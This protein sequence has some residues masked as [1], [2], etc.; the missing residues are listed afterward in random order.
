MT[1]A[2]V[3]SVG[4]GVGGTE[5]SISSLAHALSFSIEDSNPDLVVY[6]VS[7][8]SRETVLPRIKAEIPEI[9]SMEVV[10]D[11][12]DDLQAIFNQLNPT[13]KRL[14]KEHSSLY[15]DFT[16]G[17]KAMTS[18]LVMLA[19]LYEANTLSNVVGI[20]ANGLVQRGTE[21]IHK[22]SPIFATAEHRLQ[23]AAS[24]FN[25]LQFN[26]AFQTLRDLRSRTSDRAIIERVEELEALATAYKTWDLFD[27]EA[28]QKELMQVKATTVNANK[29]FLGR[30]TSA[31]D[32]TPFYVA[33][34][35]SNARRRGEVEAKY[36]D[37]VARLYRV[38][39]LLAQHRLREAH[40]LDSSDVPI[41]RLPG[42]LRLR[43]P[44][45]LETDHIKIGLQRCYELLKELGDPFGAFINDRRLKN[46]LSRRN[47]SIL[48]HGLQP[49]GVDAYEK[50]Y[51]KVYSKALS[52]IPMLDELVADSTFPT[53]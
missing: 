8:Q 23:T 50:L 7:P 45:A 49:I 48:A 22:V 27:H 20:R 11:T 18:S 43:W 39:E 15:I 40:G 41:E 51:K 32:K 31:E 1:R 6:I 26:A 3:L 37:A 16:S 44:E 34:L 5:E 35:L 12:V 24:H 30:L 33:D 28:A 4:T 46:L 10:L 36:D 25:N 9:K 42:K 53:I 38:I 13:I 14:R 19:V 52:I 21:T 47:A 29:R 17:T 2:L